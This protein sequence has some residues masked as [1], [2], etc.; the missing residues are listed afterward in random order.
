MY[1]LKRKMEFSENK[2]SLKKME[3]ILL[4]HRSYIKYVLIKMMNSTYKIYE[5]MGGEKN[6]GV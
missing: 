1:E 3:I 5:S 6:R 4:K 2:K